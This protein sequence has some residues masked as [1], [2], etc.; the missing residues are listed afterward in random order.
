MKKCKVGAYMADLMMKGM[1]MHY[2]GMSLR[3]VCHEHIYACVSHFNQLS[4]SSL[5]RASLLVL[6]HEVVLSGKAECC[7]SIEAHNLPSECCIFHVH[8][9]I[10]VRTAPHGP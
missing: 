3:L 10:L 1:F 4:L 6:Q 8:R 9:L 5:L 2:C 7:V